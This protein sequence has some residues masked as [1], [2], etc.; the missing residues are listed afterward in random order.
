MGRRTA[1][2]KVLGDPKI[3]VAILRVS[4]DKQELGPEAQRAAI[5]SW[6]EKEGL[7]VA[8][9]FVEQG[10]SGATPVRERTT[11]LSAVESL[12]KHNAGVLAFAKR[13]RL[14]R[15]TAIAQEIEQLAFSNG[16]SV[17]TADGLSDGRGSSGLLSRGLHDLLGAYEREVIRERTRA[18]MQV[19]KARG[20]RAGTIPYGFRLASDGKRLER[21]EHEHEIIR[22]ARALRAEGLSF[23]KIARRLTA[24]N[25]A[26]RKGTRWYAPQIARMME[27]AS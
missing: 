14:A 1:R 7:R 15:N 17:R 23:H 6:A 3:A 20:E 12:Q 11:L 24:E 2:R 9:W 19:K 21:D 16:A 26:P 8:E 22:R 5:K 13:D 25:L 18:A 27:K 4:T 10:V